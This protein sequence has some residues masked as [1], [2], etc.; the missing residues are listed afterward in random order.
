LFFEVKRERFN[1]RETQER[2]KDLNRGVGCI[3]FIRIIIG[4]LHVL[5]KAWTFLFN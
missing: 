1:E 3:T 2:E 4:C 5:F